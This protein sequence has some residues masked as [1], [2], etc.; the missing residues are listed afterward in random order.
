MLT[1]VVKGFSKPKSGMIV[2]HH[3]ID[4]L[5]SEYQRGALRRPKGWTMGR[6]IK[7]PGSDEDRPRDG[8]RETDLSAEIPTARVGP[9]WRTE[10]EIRV[11]GLPAE[12]ITSVLCTAA[13]FILLRFGFEL[14]RYVSLGVAF[15]STIPWFYMSIG[16]RGGTKIGVSFKLWRDSGHREDDP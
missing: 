4:V 14:N 8:I 1:Y 5:A 7:D 16:R 2:V 10:P 13:T 9:P 11:R 6:L 12:M 15:V 3:L